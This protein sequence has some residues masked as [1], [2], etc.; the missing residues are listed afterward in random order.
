MFNH[1]M[2]LYNLS[3]ASKA[4]LF[5]T[6]TL[7]DRAWSWFIALPPDSVYSD[8][9]VVKFLKRFDYMRMEKRVPEYLYSIV[10]RPKET[11]RE[12]MSRFSAAML[13]VDGLTVRNLRDI[14]CSRLRHK[15]FVYSLVSIADPKSFTELM[16]T[17]QGF[18]W[19]EDF[20][21]NVKRNV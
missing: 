13:E 1:H 20:E 2:F 9:L 6:F 15:E 18:M 7:Y 11:L 10:Q 3:D 16:D 14:L 19:A 8:D 4:W 21:L 12:F 5:S 17:A